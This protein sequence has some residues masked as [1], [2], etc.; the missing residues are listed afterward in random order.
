MESREKSLEVVMRTP[1]HGLA[2]PM[3][4]NRYT[5]EKAATSCANLTPLWY[6]KTSGN[7]VS[8]KRPKGTEAR[9]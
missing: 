2:A 7:F 3:A 6:R 8:A 4:K 1:V 5:H 9:N